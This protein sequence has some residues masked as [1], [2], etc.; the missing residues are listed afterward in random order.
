MHV[1]SKEDWGTCNT[2]AEV[3]EP[4]LSLTD[5]H[6]SLVSLQ[7]EFNLIQIYTKI[8]TFWNNLNRK[9]HYKGIGRTRFI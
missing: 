3:V 5:A 4:K 1:I 2:L 9:F 6:P 7:N 8:K